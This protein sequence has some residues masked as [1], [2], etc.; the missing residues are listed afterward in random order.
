M[1]PHTIPNG[2]S[3]E[4]WIMIK[5]KNKWV[6]TMMSS[7]LDNLCLK[8]A[9]CEISTAMERPAAAMAESRQGS[10]EESLILFWCMVKLVHL[11]RW[12]D[13][14]TAMDHSFPVDKYSSRRK[15]LCDGI[16]SYMEIHIFLK[17][18]NGSSKQL[19]LRRHA[20]VIEVKDMA[21][22]LSNVPIEDQVLQYAGKVLQDH[23]LLH[24]YGVSQDSNIFLLL[25]LR[26]GVKSTEEAAQSHREQRRSLT[27]LGSTSSLEP[28]QPFSRATS[29][30]EPK[31]KLKP[32]AK[33]MAEAK[34]RLPAWDPEPPA[35]PHTGNPRKAQ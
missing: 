18:L 12:R 17:M 20:T 9:A 7:A 14:L 10:G 35:A 16:P 5:K 15:E 27:S 30:P 19:K 21:R 26:G 13:K 24:V 1:I 8:P 6:L 28:L 31:A 29:E 4:H 11:S 2:M 32:N 23:H 22:T 25:R 33:E 34:T 3:N